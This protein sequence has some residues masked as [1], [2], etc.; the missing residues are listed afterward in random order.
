MKLY[1]QGRGGLDYRLD[2]DLAQKSSN[3]LPTDGRWNGAAAG[4]EDAHR[5]DEE[6]HILNKR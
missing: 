2:W 5:C 1:T 3:S 4:L 6:E